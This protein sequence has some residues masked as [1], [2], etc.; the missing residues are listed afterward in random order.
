MNKHTTPQMLKQ[1]TSF[2]KWFAENERQIF[3]EF[4]E[5]DE[6]LPYTNQLRVKFSKLSKRIEWICVGE[7]ETGKLKMVLSA[8][9]Y[10]KL[11]PKI[12]AIIENAPLVE[13]WE[14]KNLFQPNTNLESIKE[15]LDLGYKFF[16]F[17]LKTS[18]LY[19]TILEY[20]TVYKKMKIQVFLKNKERIFSSNHLDFAIELTLKELIGEMNL[21]RHI[22]SVQK[23][24]LPEN[25]NKLIPLY[26]LQQYIDF[27]KRINKKN[28]INIS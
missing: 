14:F 13:Y 24:P 3:L 1:I 12:N 28:G 11:I 10:R 23:A 26:K 8:D 6:E 20:N 7:S 27:L 22:S 16:D 18:D 17:S 2:W 25:K 4:I 15:G 9:G 19:F 5:N 21:R